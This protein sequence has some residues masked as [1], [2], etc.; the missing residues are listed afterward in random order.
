M[1]KFWGSAHYLGH[2]ARFLEILKPNSALGP[3][4]DPLTLVCLR[5]L[6]FITESCIWDW[7]IW[8]A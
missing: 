8:K 5:N 4:N 3:Y 7:K 2:A 6:A 1:I